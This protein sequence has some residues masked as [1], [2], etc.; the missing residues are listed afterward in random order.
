MKLKLKSRPPLKWKAYSEATG[1]PFRIASLRN[2]KG[3]RCYQL[4]LDF[5]HAPSRQQLSLLRRRVLIKIHFLFI[6]VLNFSGHK[7]KHSLVSLASLIEI[8]RFHICEKCKFDV[9]LMKPF[10]IGM[11]RENRIS[12]KILWFFSFSDTGQMFHYVNFF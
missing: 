10:N 3:I 1:S 9:F 5:S 12:R 11:K 7:W 6:I 2:R 4:P 8:S